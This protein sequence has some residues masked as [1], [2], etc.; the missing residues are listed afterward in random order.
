MLTELILQGFGEKEDLN[1]AEKIL[2]GANQAYQLNLP[3]AQLKIAAGF[4]GGM[5]IGSVCG[6]L[7]SSV[8]VLS[9]LFTESTGHQSPRLKPLIQELFTEYK[10][11]MESINCSELKT[12]HYTPEVKCKKVIAAA[13][14]VLDKIVSRERGK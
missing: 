14:Q 8:M 6:A 13:A 9:L 3:P 12:L 5:A 11:A 2:S 1:C 10:E 4:G 7:T